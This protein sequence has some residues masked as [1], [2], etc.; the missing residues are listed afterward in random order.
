MSAVGG[1]E[2]A[3]TRTRYLGTSL[4]CSYT[5]KKEVKKLGG[6][7][8]VCGGEHSCAAKLAPI[9]LPLHAA[10]AECHQAHSWG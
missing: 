8:H 3:W 2:A 4:A 6:K 9:L 10:H 7:R 1:D 5:V